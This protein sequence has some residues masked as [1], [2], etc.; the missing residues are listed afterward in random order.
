MAKYNTQLPTLSIEVEAEGV[1]VGTV[2]VP[3]TRAAVEGIQ[4]TS[5]SLAGE[6]LVAGVP[7]AG[8]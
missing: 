6:P 1:A 3:Q 8:P 7:Q 2:L 4:N 5:A